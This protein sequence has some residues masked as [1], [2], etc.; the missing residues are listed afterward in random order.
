MD[1]TNG[2]AK[3]KGRGIRRTSV[4]AQ[5][6]WQQAERDIGVART[7]LAPGSYYADAN[8]A[9]QAAEKALKAAYW[10]VR[11]EEP[12][13]NHDLVKCANQVAERVGGLPPNLVAGAKYLQPMFQTSRYPTT[14]I[15]D[16]IPA[17]VV[18]EDDARTCVRRGGGDGVGSTT[19]S[20]AT[21]PVSTQDGLLVR[22]ARLL[23]RRYGA[24]T[25]LFGSRARGTAHADSD[26][27]IV[28][29]AQAFA[30]ERRPFRARDR[31][32]LWY[33]AGGWGISLDLHCYTP[34]EF[35]KE[36]AGLGFIGMAKRRGELIRV[37]L[38]PKPL[39]SVPQRTSKAG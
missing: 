17:D 31:Y 38:K 22:F 24:R 29:V 27:D 37:T 16:P 11:R 20:A 39:R 10:E 35:R 25:Y 13:W 32:E 6:F 12:P 28:T 9:H 2:T 1:A 33:E 18:L 36:L 4:M 8:F 14:N 19:A 23:R 5:R 30:G 34:E 7:L 21:R 15:E 26:Y 3:R